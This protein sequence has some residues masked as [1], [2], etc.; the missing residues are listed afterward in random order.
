MGRSRRP[1]TETATSRRSTMTPQAS[2]L[3]P[4]V[5]SGTNAIGTTGY[6]YDSLSRVVTVKDGRHASG[7]YEISDIDDDGEDRITR[8]TFGNG[9]WIN[10]T[11]DA[12]GNVTVRADSGGNSTT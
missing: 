11:Y 2:S 12:N 1:R 10:S 3:T 8:I 7:T 4:S 9:S 5:T 6:G